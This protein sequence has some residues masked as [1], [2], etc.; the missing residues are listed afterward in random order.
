MAKSKIELKRNINE[1]IKKIDDVAGQRMAEACIHV[2]NKTKEKL[3]GN[4]SGRQYRVPGTKTYYT[5]SAFLD[6][7]EL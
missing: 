7:L 3:S 2:Q 1:A 5:A 4:R 6:V